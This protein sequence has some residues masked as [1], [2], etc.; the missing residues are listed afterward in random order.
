MTTHEKILRE[1]ARL[2]VQKEKLARLSNQG[3]DLD[4]ETKKI[5]KASK[6][7]HVNR[8]DFIFKLVI[9]GDAVSY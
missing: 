5:E 3:S 4:E 1:K 8:F 9:I 6:V 2:D 7:D